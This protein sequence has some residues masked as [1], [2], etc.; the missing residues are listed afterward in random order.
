MRKI[1]FVLMMGVAPLAW[2]EPATYLDLE[3]VQDDFWNTT[4]RTAIS[5]DVASSAA[6]TSVSS[7]I[8]KTWDFSSV[9]NIWS[10]P[11]KGILLFF[12]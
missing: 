11:F 7:Q 6:A 1:A 12:R 9:V 2:A 4:G 10:T 8:L 5:V 3:P